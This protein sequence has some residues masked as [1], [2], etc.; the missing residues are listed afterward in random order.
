MSN[1]SKISSILS[2]ILSVLNNPEGD[3]VE[4]YA[5]LLAHIV[6]ENH[7]I[8]DFIYDLAN[9]ERQKI[10]DAIEEIEC[11]YSDDFT[12]DFDG[13][14]YRIISADA[15]ESIYESE[16]KMIVE[17]C[18][19]L[20]LDDIPGFVSW[21]IDWQQTAKNC[22]ADGYGHTF[23]TY[24]GSEIETDFHYIFRTN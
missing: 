10:I 21:S 22:L 23:S 5:P 6:N 14:E 15:I 11:N 7:D 24:D 19:D 13:N 4:I 16:I 18:Y 2:T 3:C 9:D 12:L 8:D 1:Q 17:D 20:K